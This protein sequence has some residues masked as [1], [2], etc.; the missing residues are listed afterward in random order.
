M[1]AEGSLSYE[2][3]GQ[4]EIMAVLFK[5]TQVKDI[6]ALQNTLHWIKTESHDRNCI[7]V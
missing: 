3:G 1:K 2:S 4:E 6:G 5:F 7:H